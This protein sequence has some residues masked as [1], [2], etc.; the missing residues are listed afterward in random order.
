M[1]NVAT[2]FFPVLLCLALFACL[3]CKEES[4]PS[5]KPQTKASGTD[6]P[7]K[8][9]P[10]DAYGR[11]LS[12]YIECLNKVGASLSEKSR[13]YF[14]Q[15]DFKRGPV[16]RV[17]SKVEGPIV[18]TLNKLIVSPLKSCATEVAANATVEPRMATLEMLA[19]DFVS[20]SETLATTYAKAYT[21]YQSKGFQKDDLVEGKML[22]SKLVTEFKA[23]DLAYQALRQEVVNIKDAQT[24][25]RLE[26]L[27]AGKDTKLQ[28]LFTQ[29]MHDAK[30]LVRAA[31]VPKVSELKGDRLEK[32]VETYVASL[33]ALRAHVKDN[34]KDVVAK[35]EGPFN[36]NT[37]AD[38][39][40][41]LRYAKELQ[42]SAQVLHKL[43]TDGRSLEQAKIRWSMP[44]HPRH[45]VKRYNSL[46]NATNSRPGMGGI[47][48]KR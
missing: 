13:S 6:A 45:L 11:K 8:E 36:N 24:L 26:R 2:R 46:V 17:R 28:Y 3:S 1:R 18:V 14:K 30:Y 34:P 40:R 27:K 32:V 44:G 10:E 25:R 16:V 35:T 9:D 41:V 15:V 21:Y 31:D 43:H 33:A 38:F 37:G 19:T 4:E 29:M 5:E 39:S 23:Y 48:W 20:T 22:H 42:T 47:R 12:P 7:P